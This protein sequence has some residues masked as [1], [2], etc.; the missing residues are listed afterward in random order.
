MQGNPAV[1]QTL[2]DAIN[3]E[4]QLNMQYRLDRRAL[5]FMGLKKVTSKINAFGDDTHRFEKC[6]IKRLLLLGGM[7]RI[8]PGTAAEQD[9]VTATFMNEL[10]MEMAILEPY[11]KAIQIAMASLDDG[12]RNL[13]EHLVKWHQDHVAWLE[14]QLRLINA[15]GE[16]EYISEKI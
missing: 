4:V 15:L 13:Y 8:N 11:E 1:L 12:T 9:S 5:S 7:V 10:K 14:K 6:V 16:D 3:A 2:A